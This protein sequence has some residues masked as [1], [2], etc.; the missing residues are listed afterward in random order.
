MPGNG[1]AQL[2]EIAAQCRALGAGGIRLALLRGLKAGAKPL[3]PAVQEAAR[4]QLPKSGGLNEQVAGQKVTVQV[5]TGARTA[6]V[7]L[8]TTA[9]DTKQTDEGYVRHPVFNKLNA[10]GKRIF[11]RQEIPDATGWWSQTMADHTP[12]VTAELY[13]VLEEINAMLT[14]SRLGL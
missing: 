3:I 10:D 4:A 5:R 7:R 14:S 1:S 13:K 6:A 11:R 2:A 12:E 9:P 8:V